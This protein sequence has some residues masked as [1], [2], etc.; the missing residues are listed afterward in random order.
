MIQNIL[1]LLIASPT[2]VA[3]THPSPLGL[4]DGV[5]ALTAL[6]LLAFEFTADNQQFAF[7]AWK[8]GTG[9]YDARTHWPGARLAWTK[10]DA[11]RGFCTRGLWAWSRHPNF[12]AEQS[13]WVC[14]LLSLSLSFLPPFAPAYLHRRKRQGVLNLIPLL[15]LPSAPVLVSAHKTTLADALCALVPLSPSLALCLLF[16]SSTRFTESIS[17]SKYPRGYAAYRTRV[18]MFVPWVTPLW[19]A[20][21]CLMGGKREVEEL[22][23]GSGA[24]EAEVKDKVN[25]A[26]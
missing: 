2:L 23:W 15:S 17:A 1:L 24:R 9:T 7:H 4:S 20:L 11:A 26:E 16:V 12:F 13:F 18:A 10:D 22:V 19:G 14:S 3:A 5:L 6:A 21:L 25:K 8:Q